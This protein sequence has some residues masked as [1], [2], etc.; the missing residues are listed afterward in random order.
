MIQCP[1]GNNSQPCGNCAEC[2]APS[3]HGC[4]IT[5]N[6]RISTHYTCMYLRLKRQGIHLLNLEHLFDPRAYSVEL[7]SSIHDSDYRP[8]CKMCHISDAPVRLLIWYKSNGFIHPHCVLKNDKQ[9]N[10]WRELW[11]CC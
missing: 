2:G 1:C 11:H 10:E 8:K 5:Y 4:S 6:E 7:T 3:C 9:F